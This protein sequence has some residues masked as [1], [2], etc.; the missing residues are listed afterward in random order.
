[1]VG[2]CN[3]D[4]VIEE[5]INASV[6][7]PVAPSK[8]QAK[9]RDAKNTNSVASSAVFVMAYPFE[10]IKLRRPEALDEDQYGYSVAQK[11]KQS[12][13]YYCYFIRRPNY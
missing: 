10:L 9:H 7:V 2:S 6:H 12:A 5:K 11:E 3:G 1:V 4:W 8:V 13:Q